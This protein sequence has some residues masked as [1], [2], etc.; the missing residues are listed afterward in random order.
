MCGDRFADPA[1][2]LKHQR[3]W[4]PA[5][6]ASRIRVTILKQGEAVCRVS[7]RHPL[8][9]GYRGLDPT[10]PL[11]NCGCGWREAIGYH[12]LKRAIMRHLQAVVIGVI[13]G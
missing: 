6:K 8:V 4:G 13:D 10:Q 9:W 12:G 1:A 7:S 2:H 3:A 5:W 11:V